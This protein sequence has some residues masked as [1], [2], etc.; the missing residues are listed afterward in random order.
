MGREYDQQTGNPERAEVTKW[1]KLGDAEDRAEPAVEF[2][3]D[4]SYNLRGPL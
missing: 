3:I 2:K 4:L 1:G